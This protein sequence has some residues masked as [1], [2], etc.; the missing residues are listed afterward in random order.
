MQHFLFCRQLEC[1]V[2]YLRKC[3]PSGVFEVC[4]YGTVFICLFLVELISVLC[5]DYLVLL[6]HLLTD[7]RAYNFKMILS[8]I[9]K[10]PYDI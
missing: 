10:A 3:V 2:C 7:F 5:F 8:G 1:S 6:E 9:Q 4:H